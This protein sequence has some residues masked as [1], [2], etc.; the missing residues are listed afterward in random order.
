MESNAGPEARQANKHTSEAPR[1][2]SWKI[3]VCLHRDVGYAGQDRT[4]MHPEHHVH[5][6]QFTGLL[7]NW[8]AVSLTCTLE[9]K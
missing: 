9:S 3:L 8:Q 5:V 1:S 4:E 7:E 6:R 2:G